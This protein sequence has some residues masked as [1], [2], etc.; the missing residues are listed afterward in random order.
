MPTTSGFVIPVTVSTP[1]C[2]AKANGKRRQLI[3]MP[4]YYAVLQRD[5]SIIPLDCFDNHEFPDALR[6]PFVE[7]PVSWVNA[8]WLSFLRGS[9]YLAYTLQPEKLEDWQVKSFKSIIDFCRKHAENIFVKN[10]YMF[11]GCP[12]HGEVYGFMQP[13][14]NQSWCIVRNPLPIPQSFP[15]VRRKASRTQWKAFL[16]FYPCYNMFAHGEAIT[17]ARP[18]DS[19]TC[20]GFAKTANAF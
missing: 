11:G 5:K 19:N 3:A 10:G 8:I 18:R 7:E 14:A 1:P 16:Q 15:I 20:L 2:P 17:P 6:N 13:G 9:T 4:L 12:S